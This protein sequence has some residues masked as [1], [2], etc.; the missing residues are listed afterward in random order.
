MPPLR[1]QSTTEESNLA[2][3]AYQTGVYDQMTRGG[4]AIQLSRCYVQAG[5]QG[6]EPCKA[7]FGDRPAPSA[8]P[9]V[10]IHS[11]RASSTSSRRFRRVANRGVEP[12]T[13]GLM[14]PAWHLRLPSAGLGR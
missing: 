10:F 12:R 5:C 1:S 11:S 8:H 3:P 14:R 4:C 6:I 13:G 2:M 7:G 9:K